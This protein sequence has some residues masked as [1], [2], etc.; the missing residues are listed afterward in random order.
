MPTRK[1]AELPYRDVCRDPEH[2]PPTHWVP[3]PGIYEH[4]CPS[5]GRTITFAVGHRVVEEA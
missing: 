1:I 4:K 2:N 3:E 5:C